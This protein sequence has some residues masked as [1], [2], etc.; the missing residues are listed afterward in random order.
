MKDFL[1]I[2]KYKTII[3]ISNKLYVLVYYFEKSSLQF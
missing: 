3:L 2:G 1:S